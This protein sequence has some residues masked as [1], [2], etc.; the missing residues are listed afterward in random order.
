MTRLTDV[1][2]STLAAHGGY[3][4][5]A[6]TGGVVPPLQPSSTFERD[7]N[8]AL[9]VDGQGYSRDKNPTNL[10]AET[11]LARLEGGKDALTFSSGMAAAVGVFQ[12]LRP[13]D[14]VV[15]PKVMYWGLRNWLVH[16][17]EDWG[18]GLDFFDTTDPDSLAACLKPGKTRLVWIETPCNPT[19]DVIDI[20]AAAEAAHGAGALLAVDS[21]VATPVHT[22]P[23]SL[24]ADIV[25]HSATKY[26]NGHSDVIAGALVTAEDSAF[27]QSIRANREHGGAILGAFEAWM[28]LRGMRTLYVR[29]NRSSD[30][31]LAIARHLNGHEKVE[32]VL[33]PGLQNHPGH[34]IA[35]RQ[36]EGGFGGMLSLR[37]KGGADAAL[38]T[39]LNCRLLVRAT[40]LG[41]TESLIEHR[42]SIEGPDSP[43][44]KDM[45]RISI[46]IEDPADLIA[47]LDQALDRL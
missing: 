6:Q 5:D 15:A 45:V 46:G 22:R 34:E 4:G 11:L 9:T 38:Q 19:W 18:L 35:R 16:F 3:S 7:E 28:L 24:G 32:E 37:I 2:P 10:H 39:A 23:L 12:A 43:I 26:L 21:T 1:T 13:G 33:Y 40:S 20:A 29:V 47:D 27:W 41:G 42:A 36:M 44:P 25:F 8:Y 14:H 31:A 30:S 17:A